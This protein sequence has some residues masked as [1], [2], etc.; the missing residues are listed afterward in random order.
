[1]VAA[2]I[3][4]Y[5]SVQRLPMAF[6]VMSA[7][8]FICDC[9]ERAVTLQS[10]SSAVAFHMAPLRSFFIAPHELGRVAWGVNAAETGV[11]ILR[12]V[13]RPDGTDEAVSAQT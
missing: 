13:G 12:G 8:P 2:A 3:D 7:L 1:M 5:F 10:R 4:C 6:V 11:N 9:D